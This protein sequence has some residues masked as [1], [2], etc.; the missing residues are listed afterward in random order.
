MILPFERDAFYPAHEE[1]VADDRPQFPPWEVVAHDLDVVVF[2]GLENRFG[3]FFCTNQAVGMVH[4][5]ENVIVRGS[6][7]WF[8]VFFRHFHGLFVRAVQAFG[9]V[10]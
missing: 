8:F 3:R 10:P 4:I 6:E 7:Y 9:V 5:F 1:H 2:D